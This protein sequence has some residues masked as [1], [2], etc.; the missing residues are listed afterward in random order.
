VKAAVL[1]SPIA[2]SLSPAL[3]NAGYAALGLDDWHYTRFELQA[4]DLP[5]FLA[6][7]DEDWRGFSLTMPLKEACLEVATMVSVQADRLGVGNTLVNLGEGRWSADNTDL[8]GMV[9][10]LRPHWRHDWEQVAVLGAGATARAAVMTAAGLGASGVTLYVRDPARA[11]PLLAWA[12]RVLPVLPVR[13]APLADWTA[14]S[15]PA[16]LSTLPSGAADGF[17]LPG[18]RGGLLFDVVYAGWPTPLALTAAAAGMQVVGG[19]D[20]LVHQ[21][22]RQF[23]LFTGHPAPLEVMFAAGRAALD[24]TP[25]IGGTTSV[26]TPTP[27]SRRTPG[28][29]PGGGEPA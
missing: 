10:A 18:P 17:V 9:D 21:A 13:V 15:E 3:H 1:G 2:H 16:V 7:L 22:A 25:S 6:G 20:L 14:G 12:V 11:E 24:P 19:L 5:G 28:A 29:L 23:E 26:T 8:G 4:A 27:S